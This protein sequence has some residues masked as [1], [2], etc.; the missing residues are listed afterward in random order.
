M[1]T[2]GTMLDDII[3]PNEVFIRVMI[4][5]YY[6]ASESL[7]VVENIGACGVP[8]PKALYKVLDSLKDRGENN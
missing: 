8:L 5:S 2:L 7:S 3:T 6:I 4:T 1:V